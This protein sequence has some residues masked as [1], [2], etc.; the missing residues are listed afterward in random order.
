M[1]STQAIS[2]LGIIT[3]IMLALLP[4]WFIWGLSMSKTK[5]IA[6]GGLIGLSAV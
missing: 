1:E 5:K 4:L 3:D 6:V 2:I